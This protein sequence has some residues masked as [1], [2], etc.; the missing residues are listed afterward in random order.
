[1]N[2]VLPTTTTGRSAGFLHRCNF[3]M[4]IDVTT[5]GTEVVIRSEGNQGIEVQ[6]LKSYGVGID[7]H[8]Q[9]IAICVHVRNN[10][11]VFKYMSEADTDWDSL[12]KSKDWVVDTI[13]KHSNPVP[14]LQQPL[15]YVIEA[16]STYH[17][18]ILRAWG[19]I[20]SVIN[21]MLAGA[22]KK[23]TDDLDAERLSFH[24]LTGVW[25]ESYVPSNDLQELRVLIAERNHYAK[26]AT[27]CSNR[28]NNIIVRFGITVG[29]GTSV[30][31]NSE[32]RAIVE[33]L[34]SETPSF[35]ENIC[36]DPL[37][38][39]IKTLIQQ[40]YMLYD[41]YVVEADSYLSRVRHKVYSMNWETRDGT[42][43]GSEMVRILCT[44]PG[45]GEITC[46]TWLAFVG[47]PRRF[48]NAK[49]LAAYCGLDPSLKVSAGHVTSTKKR[50]GCRTLHAILVT[51]ADRIIWAHSEAFGRWGFLMA[52]SSGKWKKATNAVGR[53]LCTAM[54]QIM[55]TG[56]EFT[57]ENY[58]IMKNAAIFDIPV[59]EL[60]MLNPDFKRYVKILHD[61]DI[62]TTTDM[63]TA[64]LSCSL[65]GVKGLGRK[66]FVTMQDF[67]SHQHKYQNEYKKLHS[68]SSATTAVEE[69]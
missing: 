62:H 50:G 3:V 55:L 46:F 27:Q 15:H 63:V 22:T 13:R 14:D 36:P 8:S 10:Q 60:P 28:I 44:T 37:P 25:P 40:E 19:G 16:T 30:T 52:K 47:T 41:K 29:R 59:D 65:G 12:V 31:K 66:F 17:M 43:P 45:V 69:V 35:H 21:P 18:P 34:A 1:M 64:Y 20:P 57:Y 32:V 11:R 61:H 26:L 42:I 56:R 39:D 4:P 2:L 58:T 48:P 49:A 23:K 33:D 53:K 7:C 38:A 24:D 54:H 67:L 6:V 51:S 68:N 9:F 5:S